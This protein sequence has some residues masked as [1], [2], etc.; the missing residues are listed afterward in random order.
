[1]GQEGFILAKDEIYPATIVKQTSLLAKT[2]LSG[3][4]MEGVESRFEISRLLY[5]EQI[6]R[7]DPS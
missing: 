2:S 3:V 5:G 4:I 7:I 1:M 6:P